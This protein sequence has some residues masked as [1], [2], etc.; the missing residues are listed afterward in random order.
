[1]KNK[2]LFIIC[3]ILSVV[4]IMSFNKNETHFSLEDN[5][6]MI[7]LKDS[8]IDEIELEEY[9]TGVVS[10]EM[11]ASFSLEALKA[12][13]IA[14]RTYAMYKYEKNKA[15]STTSN[16][17]NYITK[18]QMKEKWG[19]NYDNYYKKISKAV[20][21]TKGLVIKS[22]GKIICAYYF[23]MSNG[24]TENSQ[25]VFKEQLNYITPVE[26]PWEK[27][28]KNY[29]VTTN[30]SKQ[31]FCTKLNIDCK[32]ISVDNIKRNETNHIEKI[33]INN[34]VFKGTE[35]RKKLSL[36]STDF[37]IEIKDNIIITTRGYGHDVGMSQYG[38]NELAK[39]GK[40]YDEILNY[41][42]NNITIENLNV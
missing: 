20:K 42:Y 30:I 6:I 35:F 34:K 3:I 15:L 21:A 2:I 13:A 36:R 12:Q 8:T 27:D 38:A 18:D 1:M 40:T 26:S 4:Y 41:Y 32:I 10:A 28:L 5:E 22:D 23:S 39:Q 7:K 19:S 33:G 14:S 31:D 37:D 11:P 25:S 9:I 29:E 17:Q 24:I 16:D